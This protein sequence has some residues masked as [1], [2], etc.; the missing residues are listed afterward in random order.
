M[1]AC[2]FA[3]TS[4]RCAYTTPSAPRMMCGTVFPNLLVRVPR[5]CAMCPSCLAFVSA[6][7]S[8][9]K[10]L[11]EVLNRMLVSLLHM[12]RTMKMQRDAMRA[13]GRALYPSQ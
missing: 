8:S 13:L 2:A 10:T 11:R 12:Q 3:Y 9:T 1:S 6:Y 5:T 7:W 4:L